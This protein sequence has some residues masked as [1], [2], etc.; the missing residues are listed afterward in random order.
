VTVSAEPDPVVLQAVAQLAG[1]LLQVSGELDADGVR[2]PVEG[3]RGSGGRETVNG[4]PSRRQRLRRVSLLATLIVLLI[5]A[6]SAVGAPASGHARAT[7]I[8]GTVARVVDGDTIHVTVKG[9]RTVVRLV[10]ID[11]PET[12]HPSKPV[13]CWGPQASARAKRLMKIGSAIRVVSDPTQD[14]RD[15]YGRFLGYV[16]KGNNKG[17]ASVNR[18]LVATGSAKVYIYGGK[19]FTYARAFSKAQTAAR[20]AKNGLWGKPCFGNITQPQP[21]PR[22]APRPAPSP[23][24]APGGNCDPNYSGACVPVYP[25]DVNCADIGRSVRIIGSDPHKLDRDGDG[26]GCESYG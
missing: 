4:T 22:P 20:K 5:A 9:Q 8:S 23:S 18:A 13:Q 15:R 14:T 25:P 21:K 2:N 3:S 12:V 19:P 1:D 17:V 24:P 10:G 11:T 26:Y 16:Y 7:S 6:Q